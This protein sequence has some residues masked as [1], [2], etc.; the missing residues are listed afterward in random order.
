MISLPAVFVRKMEYASTKD[1]TM[2]S[3]R[4]QKIMQVGIGKK[5]M[6][7]SLVVEWLL[8]GAEKSIA[9]GMEG[10]Y[11]GSSCPGHGQAEPSVGE[12]EAVLPL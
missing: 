4:K 1:S 9:N 3:M 8:L 5:S 6:L 2:N 7:M 11:F 10:A 12:A